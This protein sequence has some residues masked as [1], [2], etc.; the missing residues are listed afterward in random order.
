MPITLEELDKE[1][2]ALFVLKDRL[3][4]EGKDKV[5]GGEYDAV[6]TSLRSKTRQR[7]GIFD[8]GSIA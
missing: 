8:L 1:I 6:L 7:L 2:T 3:A 5:K 4:S